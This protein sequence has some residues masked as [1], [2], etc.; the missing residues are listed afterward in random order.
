M[1]PQI[2]ADIPDITEIKAKHDIRHSL[3]IDRTI[4]ANERTFLAYTRT[5]LTMLVPGITFIHFFAS[6][7]SLAILGG[8]FIPA[9]IITFGYGL[10]RFYQKKSVIRKDKEMLQ[11]M[12]HGQYCKID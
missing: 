8:F 1:E 12:L 2:I 7:I 4:L 3:A 9:G 6:S 5:S 10:L 11:E